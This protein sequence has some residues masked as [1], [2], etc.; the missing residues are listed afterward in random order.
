MTTPLSDRNIAH[1]AMLEYRDFLFRLPNVFGFGVGLRRV[2]GRET[3]EACVTV[4]V[5]R[6]LP[7]SA[8]RADERVPP[9]LH[10]HEGAVVITD[11]LEAHQPR[12]SQDT[13]MYR[14]L[15]GGCRIQV[16]EAG[17]GGGIAIDRADGRPVLLT[18]NH[19]V[20]GDLTRDLFVANRLVW[21]PTGVGGNPMAVIGLVKRIVPWT[22]VTYFG[23]GQ[24]PESEWSASVDAAICSIDPLIDIGFHVIDLGVT[25]Y[26]NL[27]SAPYPGMRV[28]KRGFRSGL[29]FGTVICYPSIVRHGAGTY[30]VVVENSFVVRADP[31]RAFALSGDSGSLIVV[32][33]QLVPAAV[34][35]LHASDQLPGGLGYGSVL[36]NVMQELRLV[37]VGDGMLFTI[38]R[39]ALRQRQLLDRWPM[40]PRA[41]G[42][43][44]E[45]GDNVEKFRQD[46]LTK[47]Q[48]GGSL[49]LLR[50]L[51][52][53]CSNDFAEAILTDEEFA[54]LLDLA[55]GEWL[56]RPTVFDMLE[57]RLPDDFGGRLEK[58]F[59]R[60][61]ELHHEASAVARLRPMLASMPKG[62]TV[63]QL[64]RQGSGTG[65]EARTDS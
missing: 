38:L 53:A 62:L 47:P 61:E 8:L 16:G 26:V 50:S 11:V 54:G 30:Q 57:Y 55:V 41:S 64:L 28:A 31:E 48:A 2:A 7:S 20:T 58:A 4:L 14:P 24:P 35:L 49:G 3:G 59:A 12:L 40:P 9:T 5:T 39:R 17:T 60:F 25:R 52:D 23:G 27:V 36:S 63:R 42:L 1:A 22:L 65:A 56:V 44:G 18:C 46:H 13:A 21:Q 34:G 29:T 51:F 6:K 15:K 33:Q 37:G 45:F 32:E 19:V 43:L 10:T